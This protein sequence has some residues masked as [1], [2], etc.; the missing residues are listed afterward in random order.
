VARR[1]AAGAVRVSME[2]D[3]AAELGVGV[4]DQIVWDVQG[5]PLP[6]VVTSIRRVDWAS[7]R[8]NFYAVFEPGPWRGP[9]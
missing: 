4:G 1:V 5:R 9:R 3:I 7:F 8:P 2:E 6:S